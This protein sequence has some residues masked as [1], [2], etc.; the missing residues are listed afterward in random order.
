VF[1]N[2]P[3]VDS[4]CM[5]VLFVPA[6]LKSAQWQEAIDDVNTVLKTEPDNVKG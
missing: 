5:P 3:P 2:I 1:V 6:G 4:D